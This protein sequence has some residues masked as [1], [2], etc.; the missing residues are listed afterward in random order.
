MYIHSIFWIS[1]II[2]KEGTQRISIYQWFYQGH[3]RCAW[4]KEGIIQPDQILLCQSDAVEGDIIEV[5]LPKFSC[6]L[7]NFR[8]DKKWFGYIENMKSLKSLVRGS[9][10]VHWV[11]GRK[12]NHCYAFFQNKFTSSSMARSKNSQLWLR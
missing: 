5:D 10:L 4:S 7:W 12:F 6:M 1:L 3:D 11:F 2:R 9:K 8:S